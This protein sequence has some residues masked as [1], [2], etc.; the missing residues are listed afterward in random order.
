MMT[1][2][3]GS[4]TAASSSTRCQRSPSIRDSCGQLVIRQRDIYDDSDSVIHLNLESA[5]I[6]AEAIVRAASL[7][8]AVVTVTDSVVTLADSGD[9]LH[10]IGTKGS[11]AA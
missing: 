4:M 11:G 2:S 5:A 10:V 8:P 6:L 1:T 7:K 3:I 9:V